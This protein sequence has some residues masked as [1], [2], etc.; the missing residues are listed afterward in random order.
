VSDRTKAIS[1]LGLAVLIWGLSYPVSRLA[2][3]ELS[4]PA[5]SGLR[6]LFGSLSILPMAIQQRKSPA[7]LAYTE[8]SP[9]LWLKV[10]L[11]VG[12]IISCGTIMQTYALTRLP[13]GQV[14]FI[15][16]LYCSLVPV[17]ALIM[18]YVPRPLVLA[19]LGVS[20]AGLYLLTG[21]GASLGPAAG[22]VMA[23]NFFWSSQIVVSGYFVARVNTWLVTLAH[24]LA[25]GLLMTGAAAAFG[26]MPTWGV[27][28]KTLPFTMWGILS[29]G[30]AY[31]CQTMAQREL[32]ATAVAV[33]LPM[34]SVVAALAGLVFLDEIMTGRMVWGAAV[35]TLGSLL[36]QAAR[37]AVRLTP[38]HRRYR[39]LNRLRL[40]LAVLSVVTVLVLVIWAVSSNPG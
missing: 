2:L 1:L 3:Q 27:F 4:A 40:A 11:L 35:I 39:F 33:I 38:E 20:L 23:A 36:A 37:D 17:M 34:S 22:L 21:G 15:T 9:W 13:A 30:V 14:S 6:F 8:R 16:S 25:A 24:T 28:F 19:G 10:G 7:S 26:L 5:F 31:T 18:G 29:V 32:S 12:L